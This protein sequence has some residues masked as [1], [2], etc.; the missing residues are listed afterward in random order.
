MNAKTPGER[1]SQFVGFWMGV[2]L[3]S[4]AVAWSAHF[5][6]VGATPAVV[7]TVSA[8]VIAAGAAKADRAWLVIDRAF[9]N[10]GEDA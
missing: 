8:A 10:G 9:P 4:A 6:S 7:Y 1:R 5:G 3:T 2:A